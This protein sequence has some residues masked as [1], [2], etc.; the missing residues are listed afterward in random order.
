MAQCTEDFSHVSDAKVKEKELEEDSSASPLDPATR[1]QPLEGGFEVEFVNPPTELQ[2]ECSVCLQVLCEPHQ[3]T[4]CGSNFCK[5]CI[6]RIKNNSA[7]CPLCNDSE[8]KIFPD[9]RLKRSLM[10]YKVKCKHQAKGCEWVGELGELMKHLNENPTLDARQSGCE[11]QEVKCTHCEELF[12]RK[13]IVNHEASCLFRP[14]V[15]EYCNTFQSTC[16]DV[17]VNH[18]PMCPRRPIPCPNHCGLYPEKRDIQHHLE[19]DCP[20][21]AL[22]CP[23]AYAGC[24]LQLR[25]AEMDAHIQ[26]NV[27]QHAKLMATHQQ[28]ALADI[29]GTVV[30]LTEENQ[31]LK[32]SMEKQSEEFKELLQKQSADINKLQVDL[33]RFKNKQDTN[34]RAIQALQE[35]STIAPIIFTLDDFEGRLKRKDM[36]WSPAAFYTHPQGY[37]MLLCVDVYGNGTGKGTHMSVFLSLLR[38]E[39]DE[40][41]KWPF[42]ASITVRL[43][44][45]DDEETHYE[46]V[47]KY[48]D[49][50]PEVTAGRI[51]EE[52][53]QGRP[54]GKGKFIAHKEL[55]GKYLKDNCL[56]IGIGKVTV[57]N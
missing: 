45:Q 51:Q 52:G 56:R 4:C 15:C 38:G 11:H 31:G 27:T 9:K 33:T 32:E 7:P 39:F 22:K 57:H 24:T 3:A 5:S 28:N 23:F 18:W 36:G 48:H 40:H 13:D 37:K 20:N 21:A 19:N 41:L 50:T 2:Y 17:T 12:T 34:K 53:R 6:S 42:R 49:S 43:E 35:H 55:Y 47:I 16:H 26:D 1:R 44:N 10:S 14:Y 54:W 29:S 25:S 8:Y 30:K 46:E